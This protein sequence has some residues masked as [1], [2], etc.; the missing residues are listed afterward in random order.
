M[1]KPGDKIKH[2]EILG[3]LGKGGMGEVY[4]A[5]DTALDRKVAIKFLPE[6]MQKDGTA[7]ARLLRE[8]KAAASLD[9][10]FICKIF[11]TGEIDNKS[12]IVMEYVEGKDLR[13]KLDEGLLPLRDSLQMAL[14][15]AE[16]LEEAHGKGIAHRDLKPANI[17]LTP[18]GHVKVMDF[19]LA[20]QILPKGEEAITKTLTQASLTEQGAIVGTLAY[21]SP[22]QAKGDEIDERS[23]IFSLGILLYEMASGNH[24]F[25][26]PSAIETLSSILRD[27]TPAVSV[28]PKMV[29]PVLS[30]ILRRA[31]AKDPA[32]RYQKVAELSVEI[33]K[34]LRETVGGPRLLFRGWQLVAGAALIIAMIITGAWFLFR[35]PEVSL[36][37][38]SPIKLSILISD[39]ENKTGDPVFEG[40]LEQAFGL[41]L[42]APLISIYDR[43][44]AR[45]LI[46]QLSPGTDNR[47]DVEQAKLISAREGIDVIVTA[48]IE[49]KGDGYVIKV[50]AVDSTTSRKIVERTE[51][52]K[53][54]ADVLQAVPV[55]AAE[56]RS[57]LSGVP[58]DSTQAF[59]LE[60]STTTSL[61]AL[62]AYTRAQELI[63]EGKQE[64]AIAEYERAIKED[65]EYGRAYSGLGVIYLF[66]R[67]EREKAKEYLEQALTH[68][69]TMTEREKYRTR[70][71]W[72]GLTKDYQKIIEE[73]LAL[74]EKFPADSAAHGNLS[75]AYAMVRDMAKALEHGEIMAELFPENV[76][77]RF[78]LSGFALATGDF[79]RAK[80]ESNKTL[81][82][83]PNHDGAYIN[84]ALSELGLG[85]SA[86]ASKA[87][88]QLK[89]LSPYTSSL[90]TM[91]LADIA[92][93]EGR[94]ESAKEILQ[95]GIDEDLENNL[96]GL[97]AE[98]MIML[99]HTYLI[100]G[101]N[102]LAHQLADQAYAERKQVDVMV[103]VSLI[104][105]ELGRM[106]NAVSI[107][108]E[109]NKQLE[110]E[111]RAYAKLIEG[112]IAKKQGGIP[113]AIELFNESQQLINTWLV[114]LSLGKAYL[115]AE[116]FT[117][118]HSEFETC[119]RRRGESAYV[120]FN[121]HPSFYY[122]P[123]IH[124]YLG[125]AL[126]GIGSPGAG[127]AYQKFLQIKL[128][129]KGDWMIEDAR[130]RLGSL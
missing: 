20:K 24:P 45:K 120:Y 82:L 93:Y 117:K 37:A 49:P 70:C 109:F 78:N 77:A 12:Y 30:P 105:L 28:T 107:A 61:E 98:K 116:A 60:T 14:E 71:I 6:E 69:E 27:P 115:D 75:Y 121:E 21:M 59:E 122:F 5:Q 41:G 92:L 104:Y 108:S 103:P 23:D 96:P 50:W 39:F 79:E 46:K 15:I 42:D 43:P 8:A 1:A 33:R 52:I 36:P 90:G 19:G 35:R 99:A 85:Q 86:L 34:L 40:A 56:L 74:L 125:R 38:K 112:E 55:L 54:K 95:Q 67:G 29:N 3:Q 58:L 113:K 128:K 100:L 9:H 64:E 87:Y 65:P 102:D 111:P 127:D 26:K 83:D 130:R 18:Q 106:D 68:I 63:A 44:T 114:H 76:N 101:E 123:Q 124:Y 13:D 32:D 73:S 4:L 22:E 47:L 94:L 51:T 11:E 119:L 48:S 81:E 2:Y 88:E 25:S 118:A 17:M 10:P 72:Y 126:E 97:A 110:S 53:T 16:A 91:G 129:G 66:Y 89:T 80:R 7:R 62:N 57:E 84:L 31:L